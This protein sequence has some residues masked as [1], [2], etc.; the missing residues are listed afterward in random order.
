MPLGNSI[1]YDTHS[2]ETRPEGDRIS[3][4]W[5]LYRLLKEAGLDFDY[6]GG[7]HSG[8]NYFPEYGLSDNA[9]YPGVLDEQLAYILKTTILNP[10]PPV[11]YVDGSWYNQKFLNLFPTDIILLHIGTNNVIGNYPSHIEDVLKEI[12]SYERSSGRKLIVFL[13][14]II[15]IRDASGLCNVS[16]GVNNYNASIL[17]NYNVYKDSLD[18]TL[19][20]MQCGAGIDYWN[21]MYDEW[22]PDSNGYNKMAQVWFD[23][24]YNYNQAPQILSINNQTINEGSVFQSVNLD[25]FVV[26]DRD[27]PQEM[28]WSV[29]NKYPTKIN[30]YVNGSRQLIVEILDPEWSSTDTISLTV[31]DTGSQLFKKTSTYKVYYKV[32]RINDPPVISNQNVIN[33]IEDINRTIYFSDLI[34][35][36]P[37]NDTTSMTIHLTDGVHYDVSGATLI[38]ESDYN[39]QLTVPV[40]ISDGEANSNTFNLTISVIGTN[41]PPVVTSTPVE[42]VYKSSEYYYQIVVNDKD[43]GDDITFIPVTLPGFCTLD[44]TT[45][46]LEGTPIHTDV[47]NHQVKINI[48]D[49]TATIEHNFFIYVADTNY[50]CVIIGDPAL[51]INKNSPYSAEFQIEDP[52]IEDLPYFTNATIPAWLQFSTSTGMLTGTPGDSDVGIHHITIRASDGTLISYYTFDIEVVGFNNIPQVVGTTHPIYV[53]I[54]SFYELD[55]TDIDVVDTDNIYPDDFELQTYSGNNYVNI[56]NTLYPVNNFVGTLNVQV[57]VSDGLNTSEI[58]AINVEVGDYSSDQEV[59][60]I[61]NNTRIIILPDELTILFADEI[62]NDEKTISIYDITGSQIL[63]DIISGYEN[64]ITIHTTNLK[65]GAF[66][67]VFRTNTKFF[68]KKII[69]Y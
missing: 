3:Y 8:Y 38:P 52:D 18:L 21:D 66:I 41:D 54:N 61:A 65:P 7:E 67:I 2:A 25:N 63:S 69:K 39:G 43:T 12:T 6:V 10:G 28:N 34:F 49:N 44:P 40:Y 23:A 32:N 17:S 47:G 14:K 29:S 57:S 15:S 45:G 51:S 58:S 37:D 16:A 30:A 42:F 13:A 59:D 56:D 5:K 33:C 20:D 27:S 68:T 26:D 4:R 46:L 11:Q 62:I 22:H 64:N 53:Q 50:P 9:G 24:L 60:D 48:T 35:T 55:I 36:D 19:V 1:T 31:E